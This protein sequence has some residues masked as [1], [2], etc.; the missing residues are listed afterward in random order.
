MNHFRT[1]CSTALL[2][3]SAIAAAP[4]LAQTDSSGF[5]A[6]VYAQ[7][8][9]LGSTS[10]NESG[11]AGF[12][13]PLEA[14][15]DAGLGLG[16]DIGYIYG[17][18]WAAEFEWN[19][20]RHDLDSL[21]QSPRAGGTTAVTDGDFAS[22]IFF[23]NGVRRFGATSGGW[24]PYAGAGLGW[25]QEIDFDLNSGRTERAWADQGAFGVQLM[26]GAEIPLGEAWNLTA[27][28]RLL[29]VGSVELPAEEGVTGRLAE[30]EYNPLSVQIGLR[31]KF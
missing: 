6:T 14:D 28:V 30:P 18:G 19:W 24:V 11:N 27:D 9:W 1:L 12:G 23:L 17:N 29:R 22:N 16:G 5:Y 15:F 20:R 3:L 4:A 8:S 10:F 25:V 7:S 21:Q 2:A 31:R 26:A 13:S